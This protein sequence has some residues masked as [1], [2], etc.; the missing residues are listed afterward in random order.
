MEKQQQQAEEVLSGVGIVRINFHLNERKPQR[1]F[2]QT[3]IIANEP[4]ELIEQCV[5]EM[6]TLHRTERKNL[7]VNV[8][9]VNN[10]KDR[11]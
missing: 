5:R 8:T 9:F 4:A 11:I 2:S 7:D 1:T 10:S 6:F 3:K